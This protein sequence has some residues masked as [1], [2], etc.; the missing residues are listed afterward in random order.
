MPFK[1][2]FSPFALSLVGLLAPVLVLCGED[3]DVLPYEVD[4]LLWLRV[5]R[6]THL[7]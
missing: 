6:R 3:V 7:R 5:P 4:V 2:L 1:S